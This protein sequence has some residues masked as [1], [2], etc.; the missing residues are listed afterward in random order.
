MGMGNRSAGRKEPQ[1]S[2]REEL[3]MIAINQ[4]KIRNTHRNGHR[5]QILDMIDSE[6]LRK[7]AAAVLHID[8]VQIPESGNHKAFSGCT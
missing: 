2:N 5:L 8:A 4:G 1:Y 7:K 6:G 3:Y